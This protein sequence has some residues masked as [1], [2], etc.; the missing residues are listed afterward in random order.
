MAKEKIEE[1]A[2]ESTAAKY[3]PAQLSKSKQFQPMEK[4]ILGVVL[5]GAGAYT[6]E[7]AKAAIV[8]FKKKEVV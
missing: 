3:T 4:A 5:D 6:I 7:E 2:A 1:T 8:D